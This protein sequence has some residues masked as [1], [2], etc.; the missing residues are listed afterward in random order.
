VQALAGRAAFGNPR[1]TSV[2]IDPGRL[3][4]LVA[5]LERRARLALAEIDLFVSAAGGMRLQE[6]AADLAVACAMT[7]AILQKPLPAAAVLV[8]EIGLA[9]E[10]RSAP[11]LEARLK[12]AARCG[13]D[14][15]VVPARDA[16]A[17]SAAGLRPLPV[18]G[19]EEAL[20][21]LFELGS[22]PER[23]RTAA[24]SRPAQV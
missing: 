15:A 2:G 4:L 18:R 13:F 19:L 1:R 8:G 17:A 11:R 24:R 14:S 5:V 20:Q 12:E 23:A 21:H 3:A 10:I 22:H 16:E 7:S 6:P 9:G